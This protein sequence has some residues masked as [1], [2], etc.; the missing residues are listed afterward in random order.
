MSFASTSGNSSSAFSSWP[1]PEEF[2]EDFIAPP[3]LDD[4]ELAEYAEEYYRNQGAVADFEG[5]PEEELF[6][7]SGQIDSEPISPSSIQRELA[8][9]DSMDIS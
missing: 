6:G 5:L 2:E 1:E 3:D 4:E 7:W 9:D 8:E